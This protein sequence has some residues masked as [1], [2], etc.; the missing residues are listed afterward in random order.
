MT[1]PNKALLMNDACPY[2]LW[3]R[4]RVK[5]DDSWGAVCAWCRTRWGSLWYGPAHSL[6]PL[7]LF[8]PL[9]T[10]HLYAQNQKFSVELLFSTSHLSLYSHRVTLK[11]SALMFSLSSVLALS[12]S[13][14]LLLSFSIPLSLSPSIF[15]R[16]NHCIFRLTALRCRSLR[17]W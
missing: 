12:L 17:L 13:F 7:F 5:L 16:N 11:W 15:V 8:F 4:K 10:T 1:Q 14:I 6:P 2:Q 3:W 9:A